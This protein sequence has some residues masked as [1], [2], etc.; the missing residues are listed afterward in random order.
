MFFKAATI[1]RFE[2]RVRELGLD[3]GVTELLLHRNFIQIGVGLFGIFTPI[4]LYE[5]LGQRAWASILYVIGFY[6]LSLFLQPI[7][8]K[9]ITRVGLKVGLM[10]GVALLGMT[11]YV[12]SIGA[13]LSSPVS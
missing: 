1:H 8:A 12:F 3:K 7:A 13:S 11:Y 9:I 4:F 2:H 5:L 10:L 6:V